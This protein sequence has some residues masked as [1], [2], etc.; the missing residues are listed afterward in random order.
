MTASKVSACIVG[1][2][3]VCQRLS[4]GGEMR[5]RVVLAEGYSLRKKDAECSSIDEALA[6]E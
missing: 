5:H 3:A 6:R 2:V 1:S 4:G